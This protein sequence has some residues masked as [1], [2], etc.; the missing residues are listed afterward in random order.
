MDPHAP[1]GLHRIVP[2]HPTDPLFGRARRVA[3]KSGKAGPS[4]PDRTPAVWPGRIARMQSKLATDARRA[5]LAASQRLTPEERL[6]AFLAHSR[7]ML[8]LCR[9]GERLRAPAR[10]P[11]S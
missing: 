6:N 10:E 4:A 9:A 11:G 7:L 2:Q 8:E 5:L 3:G 1:G